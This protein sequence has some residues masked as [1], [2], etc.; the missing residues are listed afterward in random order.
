MALTPG[1]ASAALVSMPRTRA[2][3]IGLSKQLGEEHAVGAEV[4]GVLR[5]SGHLGEVIG[6]DVVRADQLPIRHWTAPRMYSAPFI[7]AVRI[8]S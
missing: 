3:G 5:A 4:L 7:S 1:M 2:C 6:R 8:L